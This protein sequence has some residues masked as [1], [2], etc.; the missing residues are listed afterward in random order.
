MQRYGNVN[1]F[2]YRARQHE[3]PRPD[4]PEPKP[5]PERQ[6]EPMQGKKRCTGCGRVLPLDCFWRDAHASDGLKQHCKACAYERKK[7]RQE[8]LKRMKERCE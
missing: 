4:P 3:A 1:G 7:Y 5:R 2:I 8:L 6:E